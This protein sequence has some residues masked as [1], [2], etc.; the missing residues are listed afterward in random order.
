MM[1]RGSPAGSRG[2]GAVGFER[3]RPRLRGRVPRRR[4]IWLWRSARSTVTGRGGLPL[5]WPPGP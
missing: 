1:P 5:A 2:V 4:R 3:R